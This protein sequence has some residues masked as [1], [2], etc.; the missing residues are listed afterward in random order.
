VSELGLL[1]RCLHLAAS[2]L[3]VG[4]AGLLVM[5][6]HSDRPTALDWQTRVGRLACAL[7]VL[8]LTSG[9]VV[10]AQ[11]TASL[12]QRPGAALEP[13]ALARVALETQAGLVW[14]LRLSLLLLLG[15]FLAMRA[16]LSA[17]V[18]WRAARGYALGLAAA[19]LAATY[20]PAMQAAGVNPVE[21]MRVE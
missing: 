13:A 17:R 18:D 11:Q 2:I 5:A 3:L 8:A 6:G 19:A 15:V 20:L 16:D 9:A 14:T 1:A 4:G 7:V 12:E 21:A 10:L